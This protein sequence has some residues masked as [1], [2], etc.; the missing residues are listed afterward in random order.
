[1]LRTRLRIRQALAVQVS[2][3]DASGISPNDHRL[4][5][6]AAR[7]LLRYQDRQVF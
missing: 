2:E 5:A 4:E 7:N 3:Q 6:I 1:M